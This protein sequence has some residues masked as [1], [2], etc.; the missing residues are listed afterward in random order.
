MFMMCLMQKK[1]RLWKRRT[2]E[3][4]R[5]RCDEIDMQENFKELKTEEMLDLIN[6][7]H[8]IISLK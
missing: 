5:A 4:T 8:Q 7:E 6:R 1:K 3:I 2:F